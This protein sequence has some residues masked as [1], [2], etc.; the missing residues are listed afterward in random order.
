MI[1][2]MVKIKMTIASTV[3]FGFPRTDVFLQTPQSPPLNPNPEFVSMT[4]VIKTVAGSHVR[5]STLILG[6]RPVGFQIP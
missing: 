1:M 5:V 6:F 3:I 2:I 4:P